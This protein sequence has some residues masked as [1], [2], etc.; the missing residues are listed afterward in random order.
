MGRECIKTCY[1]PDNQWLSNNEIGLACPNTECLKDSY[2]R[3]DKECIQCLEDCEDKECT[4]GC[5]HFFNQG[6]C[7]HRVC[8]FKY[9]VSK[10]WV[11]N[12]EPQQ[13]G[14]I[15]YKKIYYNRNT[16]TYT[17]AQKECGKLGATMINDEETIKAVVRFV[18][19]QVPYTLVVAN[20]ILILDVCFRI[21]AQIQK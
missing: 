9:A 12:D 3:N 8:D 17:E 7:N 19:L 1:Y 14:V 20:L 18:T 13:I 6:G 16:K 10:E 2:C 11:E 4:Q 5:C 21:V 15:G